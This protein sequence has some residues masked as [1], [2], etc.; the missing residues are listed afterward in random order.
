LTNDR[1][2]LR[3]ELEAIADRLEEWQTTYDVQPPGELKATLADDRPADAI[4]ERRQALR[5]RETSRRSRDTIRTALQL[6]DDVESLTDD[7][8]ETVRSDATE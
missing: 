6:Y 3:G 4:H 5:R 8:P 1:E 2:A 7:V